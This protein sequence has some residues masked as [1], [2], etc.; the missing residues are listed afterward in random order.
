M[1][2]F[3]YINFSGVAFV[4]VRMCAYVMWVRRIR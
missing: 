2:E 1:Y 3:K 4:Y